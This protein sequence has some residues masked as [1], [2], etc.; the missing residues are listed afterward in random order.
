MPYT[1]GQKPFGL[2]ECKIKTYGGSTWVALDAAQVVSV[3]PLWDS[4]RLEGED[5]IVAIGTRAVGAEISFDAGEI[6]LDAYAVLTGG[7]VISSGETPNE[8]VYLD[9]K[10]D[11]DVPYFVLEGRAI[12]DEGG[13][14]HLMLPKCKIEGGL[15]GSLKKGAFMLTSANGAAVHD[16]TAGYIMRWKQYETAAAIA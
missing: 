3:M 5:R 15:G 11:D 14:L 12:A 16:G 1:F 9:L 4:A 10:Y 6:C 2:R 7:T 13:D 8:I